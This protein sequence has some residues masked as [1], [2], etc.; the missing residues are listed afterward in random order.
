VRTGNHRQRHIYSF[1]L[2]FWSR[3]YKTPVV[4]S[5]HTKTTRRE[6]KECKKQKCKTQHAMKMWQY[7]CKLEGGK[8]LMMD[9]CRKRIA[10]A[11][12]G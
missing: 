8:L 7:I 1:S 10:E 4:C 12:C 5:S 6:V 11:L 2:I 3:K 9:V